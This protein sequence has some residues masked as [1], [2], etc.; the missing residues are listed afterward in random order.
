MENMELKASFDLFRDTLANFII[1]TFKNPGGV[2]RILQD[3]E[4]PGSNSKKNTCQRTLM[5]IKESSG[6]NKSF[7]SKGQRCLLL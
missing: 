3:V 7:N 2:V 4:N 5:K 1:Q 6:Y